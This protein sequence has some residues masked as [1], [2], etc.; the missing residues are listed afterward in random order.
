MPKRQSVVYTEIG[1]TDSRLSSFPARVLHARRT[2]RRRNGTETG[3]LGSHVASR[4]YGLS[5]QFLGTSH[6]TSRKSSAPRLL[7][8]RRTR[9]N[10]H[11]GR[12]SFTLTR[13]GRSHRTPAMFSTLWRKLHRDLLCSTSE[14]SG[15]RPSDTSAR[16]RARVI[17]TART[18]TRFADG[19]Y[20]SAM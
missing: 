8:A 19:I 11:G 3:F 20:G 10:E 6:D 9:P 16:V 4:S 2:R 12:P 18:F 1:V 15:S 17:R 5:F 14:V 13:L 7:F